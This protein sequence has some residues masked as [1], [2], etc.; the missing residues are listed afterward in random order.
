MKR[1]SILLLSV[2][3]LLAAGCAAP[4]RQQPAPVYRSSTLPGAPPEL[5]PSIPAASGGMAAEEPGAAAGSEV[6]AYEPPVTA[7]LTPAHGP[8]VVALLDSAD[9]QQQAGDLAAAVATLERALRIEPRNPRLWNRLA[10]LR[11]AQGRYTMAEQLAAKSNSLAGSDTGLKR[12]NWRLI[13]R[14]R[15][16][17]GDRAGAAAARR[18]AATQ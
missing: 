10:G 13:A 3:L 18:H 7:P 16:A 5:R 4:P 8:A 11:L 14:A 2:L 9:G 17:R 6:R 12:S 15:D 1:S